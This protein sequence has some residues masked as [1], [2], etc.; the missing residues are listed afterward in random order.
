MMA[1]PF[2]L[3]AIGLSLSVVLAARRFGAV[4]ER[5]DA[6]DLARL[7]ALGIVVGALRLINAWDYPT[8]LL[9][10]AAAVLLAEYLAQG[11]FGL[12]MLARAAAKSL[13]VFAVAI[14]PFCHSTSTTRHSSAAFRPQPTQPPSG[15]FSP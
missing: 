7:A 9:L 1:I 5:W 13:L 6:G 4:R 10:A 3:L 14:S 8:Q 11:G 12:A 2:A 15:S